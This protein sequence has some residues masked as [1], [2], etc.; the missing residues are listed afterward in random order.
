MRKTKLTINKEIYQEQCRISNRLL[1]KCKKD[2]YSNKI[3]EVGS[4]QKQLYRLTNVLIGNKREVILQSHHI[5][6]QLSNTFGEFFMGKI[7]TI[8]NNLCASGDMDNCDILRADMKFE[9][10]PLT[11]FSPDSY[12]FSKNLFRQHCPRYNSNCKYICY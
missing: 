2:F 12:I 6:Q 9:G 11:N 4:D 1:L 8:R 5:E 3:A 7:E 10:V